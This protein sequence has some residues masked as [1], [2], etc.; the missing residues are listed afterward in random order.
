MPLPGTC[1][2]RRW[3]PNMSGSESSVRGARGEPG[4]TALADGASMLG[5]LLLGAVVS[6]MRISR[7]PVV[8]GMARLYSWAFRSVMAL[9]LLKRSRLRAQILVG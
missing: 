4:E 1:L 8:T 5:V 2:Y 3:R 6:G 7:T 9:V